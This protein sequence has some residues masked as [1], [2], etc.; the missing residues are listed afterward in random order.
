[1]TT[2][3]RLRYTLTVAL[4]LVGAYCKAQSPFPASVRRVVFLGNS[5][6]YSGKYITDI[7]VYYRAHY[8]D[9]PIEF[10]NVGL[11]SE[12]VSGLSEEGHADGKFPRP[13][14]HNRLASVL[15]L[16][17]PDL[18]F[19]SYGMNDGI[20]MPFDESRFQK[21]K[22]GIHWL[23][24][25]VVK[26]GAQIIH[27]TPPVY[28][29]LKGGKIGYAAVLD[30]YADWFISQ[31]T[32]ARWEV[33][34]VHYPM[35]Q[36]LEAHRQVDARFSVA[37]FSLAEDGV[38]PGDVGHWIMAKSILLGLGEKAIAQASDVVATLAT[39]PHTA[40]FV[41]LVAE[42]QRILKDAWLTAAGHER[43]GMKK[44]LPLEEAKIKAAKIDLQLKEIMP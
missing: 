21:F 14:L 34:D 41:A 43:P 12:T 19:A 3:Y 27:L 11:P 20:Y 33:I 9:H 16:T 28:D 37:A 23:H 17:K 30:R 24:N 38:H 31:K 10:I 5:I 1:M 22:E 32:A 36:F 13:D 40:Q 4:W 15:A 29:E 6:T 26:S 25:E 44:G 18:V 7:E 39:T 42:R 35:K 2:I 8:P